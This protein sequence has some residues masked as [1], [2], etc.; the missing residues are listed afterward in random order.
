MRE[1][2]NLFEG[3]SEVY[4]AGTGVTGLLENRAKVGKHSTARRAPFECHLLNTVA[5]APDDNHQSARLSFKLDI[6]PL[7]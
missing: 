1:H 7:A 5:M 3:V 2:H 4:Y 6:L